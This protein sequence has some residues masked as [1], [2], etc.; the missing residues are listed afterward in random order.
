MYKSQV[1]KKTPSCLIIRFLKYIVRGWGDRLFYL[2]NVWNINI[3]TIVLYYCSNVPYYSEP[4]S[5]HISE[6][7]CFFIL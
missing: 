2:F 7:W 5:R 3:F 6:S 1:Y 4:R